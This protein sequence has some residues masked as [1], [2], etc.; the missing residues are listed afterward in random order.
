MPAKYPGA[1]IIEAVI[2]S[3]R[4]L[5]S[6][7][8]SPKCFEPIIKFKP[9]RYKSYTTTTNNKGILKKPIVVPISTLK[10]PTTKAIMITNDIKVPKAYNLPPGFFS[11]SI[12]PA[13]AN[14]PKTAI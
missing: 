3:I 11:S 1:T 8:G 5:T 4:D 6:S 9:E 13:K 10:V 14:K 2:R 12:M 7:S